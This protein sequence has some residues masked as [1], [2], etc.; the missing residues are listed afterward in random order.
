MFGLDRLPTTFPHHGCED[1]GY[2][3]V[4]VDAASGVAHTG[5]RTVDDP[6]PFRRGRCSR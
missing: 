2:A 4:L 5:V 6:M 3:V 1:T